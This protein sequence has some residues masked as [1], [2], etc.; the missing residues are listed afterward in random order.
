[1]FCGKSLCAGQAFEAVNYLVNGGGSTEYG[2]PTF[3]QTAVKNDVILSECAL[4]AGT[5]SVAVLLVS[6][7]ILLC[8]VANSKFED[9]AITVMPELPLPDL[10]YLASGAQCS[11]S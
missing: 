5:V 1:M 11:S 8:N 7:H 3:S 9:A 10:H 6:N 4:T 2:P